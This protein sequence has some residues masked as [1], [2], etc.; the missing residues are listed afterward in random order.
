MQEND[1]L[2]FEGEGEEAVDNQPG[3]LVFI[4]RQKP[5]PVFKRSGAW[6]GGLAW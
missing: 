6:V 1:R 5:H 3:D 2:T 4:L